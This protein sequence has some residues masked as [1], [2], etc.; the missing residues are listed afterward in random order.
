MERNDAK[1]F[2]TAEEEKPQISQITQISFRPN[3]RKSAQSAVAT[4]AFC[5][6]SLRPYTP[7]P[8]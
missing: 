6:S 8:I 4:P 1:V 3:L 5:R 2:N 7:P